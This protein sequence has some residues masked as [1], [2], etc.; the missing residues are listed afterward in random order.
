MLTQTISQVAPSWAAAGQAREQQ[1]SVVDSSSH[2]VVS[3]ASSD[4]MSMHTLSEQMQTND[5]RRREEITELEGL[6]LRVDALTAEHTRRSKTD[7]DQRRHIH[8]EISELRD[9]MCKNME[10]NQLQMSEETEARK[11]KINQVGEGMKMLARTISESTQMLNKMPDA[12]KEHHQLMGH[13]NS[14]VQQITSVCATTESSDAKQLAAQ[15]GELHKVVDSLKVAVTKLVV[16]HESSS[17]RCDRLLEK[18]VTL[19]ANTCA[20]LNQVEE[21]Y[22][23]HGSRLDSLAASLHKVKHQLP[24]ASI[25]QLPTQQPKSKQPDETWHEQMQK[26]QALA[27]SVKALNPDG[28]E[29]Q[30]A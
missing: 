25:S 10:Q 27:Q 4:L 11:R 2:D 18:F 21:L 17:K 23:H 3:M 8:A 29:V 12:L 28:A 24:A 13:S 30:T 7:T 15:Q 16:S 6:R 26:L 9:Q 22:V 19:E 20:Q 5:S 14:A 1:Q